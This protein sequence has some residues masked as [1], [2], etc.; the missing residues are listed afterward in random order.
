MRICDYCGHENAD[1]AVFCSG[2]GQDEFI[3]P[4]AEPQKVETEPKLAPPVPD[5]LPDEEAAICPFCLFPNLPTR[6]WCKQCDAPILGV[7]FAPW[8]S[9]WACGCM[10]RGAVRGRPKAFVLFGIW[11]F[12]LP[13]L[14]A[15]LIL[16]VSGL[17]FGFLPGICL[18]LAYGAIDFT[19]LFRVTRNYFTIP[20]VR[21]D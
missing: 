17:G 6:Q 13:G 2:C 18:G 4:K 7:G 16:L 11:A 15:S 12:F 8:E 10:W 5:V 20:K 1:D 19:M 14:I 3:Q 21:L 9:A